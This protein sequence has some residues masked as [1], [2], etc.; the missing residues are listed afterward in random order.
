[1]WAKVTSLPKC[2]KVCNISSSRLLNFARIRSGP[3]DESDCRSFSS[4]KTSWN[5]TSLKVKV[6]FLVRLFM[7]WCIYE[8]YRI[9]FSIQCVN[10]SSPCT[11]N[12]KVLIEGIYIA[13]QRCWIWVQY[14]VANL[15]YLFGLFE[16]EL[17]TNFMYFPL[18]YNCHISI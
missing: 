4:C 16:W 6:S 12:W 7:L 3:V 18:G 8:V 13:P 9:F 10:T 14:T 5:E 15:P 11:C 1:M 17:L 2:Q